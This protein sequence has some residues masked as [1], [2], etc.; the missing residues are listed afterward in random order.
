M[1]H[2]YVFGI[3]GLAVLAIGA[4]YA[5]IGGTEAIKAQQDPYP[6]ITEWINANPAHTQDFVE[7]N[8]LNVES[9]RIDS[10]D[11]MRAMHTALSLYTADHDGYSTF[12]TEGLELKAL[13]SPGTIDSYREVS[14][15]ELKSGVYNHSPAA[16]P[17]DRY[18]MAYTYDIRVPV[19]INPAEDGYNGIDR[20]LDIQT[21]GPEY[22]WLT[23]T[24]FDYN[25]FR[26]VD[27]VDDP[28][29]RT[30]TLDVGGSIR[31]ERT[32]RGP[33]HKIKDGEAYYQS[34]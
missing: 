15:E 26:H 18:S 13:L 31:Y 25:Y 11:R 21:S 1:K 16:R 8:E 29:V 30:I 34:R 19:D 32:Q 24:W 22:V 2:T 7:L 12:G 10:S 20:S 23:D 33:R 17:A 4:S 27:P 3:V 5:L 14:I 28:K 9:R 6:D